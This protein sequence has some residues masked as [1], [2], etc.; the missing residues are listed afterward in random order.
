MSSWKGKV[1]RLFQLI[2][3][4]LFFS[5]TVYI[6]LSC[7]KDDNP[8]STN[9]GSG[10]ASWDAKTQVCKDNADGRVLPNS[11]CGR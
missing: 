3:F 10:S 1:V 2:L 11:C 5:A 8:A 6:N 7:S 4:L 9:C